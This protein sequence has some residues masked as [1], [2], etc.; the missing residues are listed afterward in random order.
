MPTKKVIWECK[1]RTRA[2]L[3]IISHYLRAWFSILA[4]KGYPRV[5][6]IDGFCGP[7]KYVGGEEGSPVIAAR[8]ANSTAQKYPGFKATLIFIDEE[9][10]ALEHLSSFDAIKKPHPTS[11]FDTLTMPLFA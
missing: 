7:G 11:C 5:I 1:P 9:T 3:E 4:S 2:K 8:L 10:A 6:Y